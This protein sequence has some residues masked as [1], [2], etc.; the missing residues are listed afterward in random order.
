MM[1]KGQFSKLKGAI[2]NIPIKK[3]DIRN[4][5][6]RQADSNGLQIVKL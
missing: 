4:T 5:P 1:L 2:C 3:S 6:D